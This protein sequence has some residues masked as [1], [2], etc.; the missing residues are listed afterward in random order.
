MKLIPSPLPGQYDRSTYVQKCRRWR[1]WQIWRN[2]VKL[3]LGKVTIFMQII[4]PEMGLICW[5]IWRIWRFLCKLHHELPKW[6]WRFW[7]ILVKFVKRNWR[8][9]CKLYYHWW[10]W[11]VGEF[12]H[13]YANYITRDGPNMLAN[14]AILA[15][16]MLIT[17]GF[18]RVEQKASIFLEW[19]R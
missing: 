4:S 5:R 9:Y 2:F 13:F 7:R 6:S 1:K 15:S 8:F 12:G 3:M 14:M 16:F 10:G 19:N 17:S 18:T 11:Y